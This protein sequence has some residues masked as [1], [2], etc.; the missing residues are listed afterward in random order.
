MYGWAPA[1]YDIIKLLDSINTKKGNIHVSGELSV[2]TWRTCAQILWQ[3][4]IWFCEYFPLILILHEMYTLVFF[5]SLY[6]PAL[7]IPIAI[8]D[9]KCCLYVDWSCT[10]NKR[11]SGNRSGILTRQPP[12]ENCSTI[13][14][15]ILTILYL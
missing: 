5:L 9:W 10:R 14:F 15:H 12:T 4:Y 1:A 6:Q 3:V 8:I 7:H 2:A 11:T 13:S